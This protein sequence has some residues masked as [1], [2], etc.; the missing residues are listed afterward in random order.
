LL[1]CWPVIRKALSST[2]KHRRIHRAVHHKIK[3]SHVTTVVKVVCSVTAIGVIDASSLPLPSL[4]LPPPGS[5]VTGTGLRP[6]F[7]A[8][9]PHLEL[10]IS[11][12]LSGSDWDQLNRLGDV[13]SGSL[14]STAGSDPIGPSTEPQAVDEPSALALLLPAL[15]CLIIAIQR[16]PDRA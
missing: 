13:N 11:Y 2:V 1:P 4:A 16:N 8:D 10:P 14:F 9:Y 7:T 6:D 15:V 5:A 3:L 12:V